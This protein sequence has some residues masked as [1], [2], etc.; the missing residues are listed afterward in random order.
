MPNGSAD[1]VRCVCLCLMG[2]TVQTPAELVQPLGLANM[3]CAM[4]GQDKHPHVAFLEDDV[5]LRTPA[6]RKALDA[7]IGPCVRGFCAWRGCC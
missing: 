7:M 3:G 1:G 5:L 6:V 4:V 2:C